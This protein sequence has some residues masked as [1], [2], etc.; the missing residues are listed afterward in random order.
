MA[1]ILLGQKYQKK[2]LAA[3]LTVLQLLQVIPRQ[4]RVWSGP[5]ALLQQRSLTVR[6]KTKKKKEIASTS[7]K[8]T[9]TKRP[10][11]KVTKYKE[12]R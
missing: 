6:R 10:H 7:T 3:T 5:P 12:H 8:R 11:P 2:K 4:S 9:S 1:G